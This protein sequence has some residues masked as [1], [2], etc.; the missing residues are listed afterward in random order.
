M[1]SQK[2]ARLRFALAAA[3][4]ATIVALVPTTSRAA[5]DATMKDEVRSHPS[6]AK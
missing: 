3:G 4:A 5:D 1:A 2:I 6:L